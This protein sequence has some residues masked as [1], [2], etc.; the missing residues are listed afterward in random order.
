MAD[1]PVNIADRTITVPSITSHY[2]DSELNREYHSKQEYADAIRK[3]GV[4]Y[5]TVSFSDLSEIEDIKRACR[6]WIR[7][8]YYDGV[9]S[10]TVK[11][12]DLHLLGSNK[13]KYLCGDRTTVRFIDTNSSPVEKTLTCM[14]A[15]YDL[16]KPENSSF[17]IGIPDVS[18]NI[19][20]RNSVTAKKTTQTTGEKKD[21]WKSI[22]EEVKKRQD[23]VDEFKKK[24]MERFGEDIDNPSDT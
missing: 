9:L 18:A 8:N 7:R 23:Q 12:V 3:Y 11:A 5:K 21:F 13:N 4:I 19:K 17:K 1:T 22:G 6:E 20:Y 14:S 24:W 16:L 15:Q 10:F 2:S